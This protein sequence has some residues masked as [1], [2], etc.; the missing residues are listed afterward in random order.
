MPPKRKV[1]DPKLRRLSDFWVI[2]VSAAASSQP[3]SQPSSSNPNYNSSPYRSRSSSPSKRARSSPS[4]PTMAQSRLARAGS[5]RTE[6]PCTPSKKP[7][8][9]T[10][11]FVMNCTPMVSS[12]KR[13]PSVSPKFIVVDNEG[14][15]PPPKQS[16]QTMSRKRPRDVDAKPSSF[17]PRPLEMSTNGRLVVDLTLTPPPKRRALFKQANAALPTLLGSSITSQQYCIPIS[18]A[19]DVVPCSVPTSASPLN[20][21][22][23]PCKVAGSTTSS[24]PTLYLGAPNSR[25]PGVATLPTPEASSP[26]SRPDFHTAPLT[27]SVTIGQRTKA[28]IEEIRQRA[29]AKARAT[30]AVERQT[31][32]YVSDDSDDDDLMLNFGP[33]KT[34]TS[35]EL[36]AKT[37]PFKWAILLIFPQPT[38]T[39]QRPSMTTQNRARQSL[40]PLTDP[41]Y[42]SSDKNGITWPPPCLANRKAPPIVFEARPAYNSPFASSSTSTSDSLSAPKAKPG[43]PPKKQGKEDSLCLES[44]FDGT[45]K[46]INSGRKTN[47][48]I[49]E[50]VNHDLAKL[51]RRQLGGVVSGESSGDEV[52]DEGVD[53]AVHERV[54]GAEQAG[55]VSKMLKSDKSKIV[56]I[57]PWRPFWAANDGS[58]GEILNAPVC[59]ARVFASRKLTIVQFTI[60]PLDLWDDLHPILTELKR[61][62]HENGKS[63]QHLSRSERVSF[64]VEIR[65]LLFIL[66]SGVLLAL[67]SETARQHLTTWLFRLATA[68]ET[69]PEL[70]HAAV[71]AFTNLYP[72][73]APQTHIN[74]GQIYIDPECCLSVGDIIQVVSNLGPQSDA[75]NL[76]VS[77]SQVNPPSHQCSKEVREA[78]LFRLLGMLRALSWYGFERL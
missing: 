33:L 24:L 53:E 51:E 6:S 64:S 59:V 68:V 77:A 37:A 10:L 29:R 57:V 22:A 9:T 21:I 48:E 18:S 63:K 8:Q 13:K 46:S 45:A 54:L 67:P 66:T 69:P 61:I 25:N 47:K 62:V 58:S 23:S 3:S 39:F 38:E 34:V 15:S 2:P 65:R 52:D 49:A 78:V 31:T 44:L 26:V 14:G 4:K 71:N 72:P 28:R 20:R 70:A 73:R 32:Q 76:V 60:P 7:Q 27:S 35:K 55:K 41:G 16:T 75:L 50:M 40:K 42:D 1:D 12:S 36:N 43:A 17:T 11:P 74:R 19:E 5:L 56:K 30:G